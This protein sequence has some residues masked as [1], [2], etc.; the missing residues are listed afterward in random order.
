MTGRMKTIFQI[1]KA[2]LRMMFYSPVAWLVLIVF[3][4]ISALMYF[5]AAAFIAETVTMMG[6]DWVTNTTNFL[7]SNQI[8]GGVFFKIQGYV[9]MFVPLLTMG[10]ISQELS[11]GTIKL[12]DS[13]PVTTTQIVLG[14]FLTMAVYGLA[15]I[16]VI[17]IFALF[18][19]ANI[20]NFDW[21]TIV[22]GLL[23]L[24][25]LLLTYSAIG[26]FM[27]S[28]TSYQVVAAICTFA[29]FALLDF[30]GGLG[31]SIVWLKDI[32]F[33]L[34]LSGRVEE[35]LVGMISSQDLFY[36]LI[37][38]ATFLTLTVLRMGDKKRTRSF[39]A[40]WVSYLSVIVVAV[41]LGLVTS[42]PRFMFFK[43]TTSNERLTITHGSRQILQ[44]IEGRVEVT[45]YVN[46]LAEA[47]VSPSSENYID[48]QLWLPY[49]RYKPEVRI[50][51]VYYWHPV[52]NSSLEERF[53]DL[54]W[55]Q[56]AAR[57]AEINEIRIDRV[58][59]PEQVAE[60]ADLSQESYRSVMQIKLKDGRSEFLRFYN[61]NNPYPGEKEI[62]AAFK[63]L[64]DGPVNVGFLE[65]HGE[66][67][68]M[69][70]RERDYNIFA[71][72][73]TFRNALINQGFDAV[74][75]NLRKCG[76]IPSHID[77]LVIS[78]V[79]GE[80]DPCERAEKVHRQRR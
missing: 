79:A 17:L 19:A 77:I 64:A 23:G 49:R 66:R 22:S 36:F 57:I 59:T 27:S 6:P 3:T 37:I 1:A 18:S 14:K 43:D 51:H 32:T 60:M 41:A 42:S 28:L 78:D 12:L 16:F 54:T 80:L 61:E 71:Y 34:G 63:R 24:Y 58:K 13:S 21:P 67:N 70:G 46:L 8:F 11:N 9:Y 20:H 62:T 47:V 7:F 68:V 44:Q 29:L 30:V 69:S 10:L 45:D 48:R 39:T 26:I 50:N 76:T 2:D 72:E 25:L 33:W 56:R 4:V 75:I 15:L 40:R 35:F 55:E 53:P 38:T 73:K 65:G 5:D 31:Q 52:E 74:P